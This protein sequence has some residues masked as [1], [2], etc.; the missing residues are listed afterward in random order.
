VHHKSLT[1]ECVRRY[2]T[3]FG[4]GSL[5]AKSLNQRGTERQGQQR[6]ER[7][8]LQEPYS[9]WP[10]GFALGRTPLLFRIFDDRILM[11]NASVAT[12]SQNT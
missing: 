12:R 9:A 11:T 2:T 4:Q 5:Y 7:R 3:N 1:D 6:C 8:G 10:F